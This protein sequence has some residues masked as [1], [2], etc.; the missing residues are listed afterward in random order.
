MASLAT[1]L[2]A[3]K[4]EFSNELTYTAGMALGD[5]NSPALERGG[6]QM[7]SKEDTKALNLCRRMMERGECPPLTV[8]A[9]KSIKESTIITEYVGDVDF[10]VNREYD[11]G[12]N[13]RSNISRFVNGINNHTI[14]GKKKQNLKSMRFNVDG[15]RLYYD[16]NGYEHEYPSEHFDL[17]YL[18]LEIAPKQCIASISCTD[19]GGGSTAFSVLDSALADVHHKEKLPYGWPHGSKTTKMQHGILFKRDFIKKFIPDLWEMLKVAE[20]KEK[21]EK[22]GRR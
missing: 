20:E 13:K 16:Y 18:E 9:D 19:G 7:F 1:A 3:T 2:T 4:T 22:K 10:L 6:M 15:E 21:Q 14:E 8:E 12:D 17:L 11:N 5:A